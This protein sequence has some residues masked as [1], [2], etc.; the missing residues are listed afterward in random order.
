MSAAPRPTVG[1][2]VVTLNRAGALRRC[3]E[4]IRAQTHAPAELLV[5]DNGSTDGTLDL[6]RSEFPEASLVELQANV[7]CPKARN[8]AAEQASA[9]VLLFVD[10][11]SVLAPNAVE[12]AE[13]AAVG[14]ERIAV[15]A[16]RIIEVREGRRWALLDGPPRDLARFIGQCAIR[17]SLIPENG[18]YPV[19]FLY[20]GEEQALALQLIERGL[21]IVYDPSIVVHHFPESVGRKAALE[22]GWS[23]QNPLSV[24]WRLFP[25]RYAIPS[26]VRTLALLLPWAIKTHTVR[27]YLRGVAGLPRVIRAAVRNRSPVSP[28]AWRRY[29]E[30]RAVEGR[31]VLLDD[32][33]RG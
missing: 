22:M 19:E 25:Y 6:V 24:K 7:G 5:V 18:L 12:R 8:L 21:R 17:R 32:R 23:V 15:F 16:P 29:R 4:S 3:L 26:T 1:V 30:L 28:P 20:Y 10:D 33:P 14:D 11:D 13:E 9:D 31:P 2:Y 27:A